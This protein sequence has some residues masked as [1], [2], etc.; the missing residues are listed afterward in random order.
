MA[1]AEL[2]DYEKEGNIVECVYLP[3]E[4]VPEVLSVS[5]FVGSLF[6]QGK[7]SNIE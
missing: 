3:G 4:P 6:T 1:V 2:K 7:Q 5:G